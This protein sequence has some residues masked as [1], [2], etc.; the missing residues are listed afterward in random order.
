MGP[1]SF[2]GPKFV[3]LER[4]QSDFFIVLRAEATAPARHHEYRSRTAPS[5]FI[6]SCARERRPQV[7]V[8]PYRLLHRRFDPWFVF[9]S[10]CCPLRGLT[11]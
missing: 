11:Q 7:H 5:R 3:P 1:F 10:P 2:V 6:R 8:L 4:R 9:Y